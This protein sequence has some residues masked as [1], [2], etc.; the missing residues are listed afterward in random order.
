MKHFYNM[1]FKHLY[2]QMLILFLY[3]LV[4]MCAISCGNSSQKTKVRSKSSLTEN[5]VNT[6]VLNLIRKE[7]NDIPV[8]INIS[9][10]EDEDIRQLLDAE[11]EITLETDD[12]IYIDINSD[13]YNRYSS[14][15]R[16]RADQLAFLKRAKMLSI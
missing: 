16:F 1:T 6:N 11:Y 14:G 5:S 3:F 2:M 12:D 13:Y 8:A 4:C 9:H 7:K 15:T 10:T